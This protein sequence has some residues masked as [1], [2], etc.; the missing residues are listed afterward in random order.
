MIE[1]K[2]ILLLSRIIE[3]EDEDK[4]L[5]RYSFTIMWENGTWFEAREA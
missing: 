3:S 4:N 2:Q 1:K 5:E